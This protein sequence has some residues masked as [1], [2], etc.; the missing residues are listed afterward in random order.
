MFWSVELL[1]EQALVFQFMI[2]LHVLKKVA[3]IG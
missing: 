2:A 1:V 3:F